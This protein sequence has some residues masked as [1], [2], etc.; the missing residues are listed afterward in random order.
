M[1][2]TNQKARRV[3]DA[4]FALVVLYLMMWILLT[5]TV[6]SDYCMCLSMKNIISVFNATMQGSIVTTLIIIAIGW[7]F[8]LG[9]R[10]HKGQVK[11]RG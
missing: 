5:A 7:V 11:E 4:L 8:S 1:V 6:M 10:G 9:S 2:I 3:L